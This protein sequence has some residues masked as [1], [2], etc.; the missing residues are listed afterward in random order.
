M[1]LEAET[2][3]PTHKQTGDYIFT[4]E[5]YWCFQVMNINRRLVTQIETLRLKVEID[6]RHQEATRAGVKAETQAEVKSRE[7]QLRGL[8][9]NLKDKDEVVK[10]RFD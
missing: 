3:P 9:A 10:V 4:F 5:C 7:S 6:A 1:E 2:H 8:K